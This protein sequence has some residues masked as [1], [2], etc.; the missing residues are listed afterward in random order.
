[1][2]MLGHRP[3][4]GAGRRARL[5]LL[6]SLAVSLGGCV[7]MDGWS[8]PRV[9]GSASYGY[10]AYPGAPGWWGR[11]VASIDMF[12]G[13][14]GRWGSW[15]SDP[16]YGRVWRPS[17]ISSGWRPYMLGHWATDRGGRRW[18][19]D[20][21]FG[22][23]TYHYGRW[24]RNN[25]GWFWVPGRQY[26][27]SWVDWNDRGSNIGW[28]PMPPS[29]WDRH[30]FGRGNDWWLYAPRGN[31]WRPSLAQELARRHNYHYRPASRP[32]P[33]MERRD[34]RRD[35]PAIERSQRWR[36]GQ[37]RPDR[38][39]RDRPTVSRPGRNRP[40]SALPPRTGGEA[41]PRPARPDRASTRA[42]R[43]RQWQEQRKLQQ[44]SP[45]PQQERRVRPERQG[46][47]NTRRD[48]IRRDRAR[49]SQA[50][51]EISRDAR[52]TTRPAT[53]PS[54][55]GNRPAFPRGGPPG[56]HRGR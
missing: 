46:A 22:W 27:A 35:R 51:R 16:Y 29:G 5:A 55:Q 15:T 8:E 20:E 10:G 30:G 37:V 31:I 45:R 32:R 28:A 12:Y 26:G 1:M 56:Q 54:R 11:D 42:E 53:R 43:T 7:G 17:G 18:I 13:S 48:S 47:Q 19:S 23:A 3:T 39:V 36:P 40:D 34:I 41:R 21:P 14:L 44:G 49:P 25:Q 4:V 33:G 52:P 9:Y 24:G 6:L 38:P 2:N 50:R